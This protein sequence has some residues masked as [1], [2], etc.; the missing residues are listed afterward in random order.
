MRCGSGSP[1]VQARRSCSGTNIAAVGS[2]V[3]PSAHALP[4]RALGVVPDLPALATLLAIIGCARNSWARPGLPASAK[5]PY[6]QPNACSPHPRFQGWRLLS[7][8]GVGAAV[9]LVSLHGCV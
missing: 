5:R 9:L 6:L 8:I 4:Q 3:S 2:V 7:P 1:S